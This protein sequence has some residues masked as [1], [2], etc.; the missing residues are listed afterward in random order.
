MA[1]TEGQGE[2][3]VMIMMVAEEEAEGTGPTS[4]SPANWQKKQVEKKK[5]TLYWMCLFVVC[6]FVL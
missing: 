1:Q 3:A 2:R 6:F 4:S 5:R